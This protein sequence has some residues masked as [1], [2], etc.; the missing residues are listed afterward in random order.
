MHLLCDEK[1]SLENKIEKSFLKILKEG[2]LVQLFKIF[3]GLI[4]ME[5]KVQELQYLQLLKHQFSKIN[6]FYVSINLTKMLSFLK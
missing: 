1:V 2:L 6:A 3:K 4:L 5:T